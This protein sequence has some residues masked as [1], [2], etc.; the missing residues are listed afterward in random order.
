[1]R[2][3]GWHITDDVHD[4]LDHA[5]DF[6]RSR[7][8]LHTV[9]LTV[10]EGLRTRGA[11]AYGPRAPVFGFLERG[12]EVRGAFFRTPPRHPFLTPLTAAD[13]DTLAA[14]LA[15]LGH[16]LSGVRADHDTATAFADAW[17]RR[18]GATSRLHERE[19]LYR[20]A[21]LTPPDPLP[22]GRSRIAGPEDREQLARWHDEFMTAVG[23]IATSPGT[24]WADTR[25]AQGGVTLWESPDGTPV[26]MAGTTP[27]IA[28]QVRVAPVYTPEPFRGRGY[29][30]AAT[31]EVSR[32]ALAAGAEQVLLFTDLANATSN[33][34]YQRLGYR[35]VTD[36]AVYDFS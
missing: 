17:T 5:G 33:A 15:R 1:M 32:A 7:P 26:A 21:H 31:A 13:A 24:T 9:P 27:M 6:L 10:T 2:S 11:D 23:E 12:G 30:G 29:A 35:P 19:R 18:T 8:D 22:A 14:H 36:F 20:L 16:R 34:L 3:D 28:G 4:F 25:I